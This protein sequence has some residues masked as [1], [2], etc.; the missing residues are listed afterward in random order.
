MRRVI[1]M[2]D[3]HRTFAEVVWWCSG[4]RASCARREAHIGQ[5]V[6][7]RLIHQFGELFDPRAQLI[8]DLS[9]FAPAGFGVVLGEGGAD[10][11]RPAAIRWCRLW[12]LTG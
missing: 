12:R 11:G 8:S 5:H 3:I 2:L 10:E 1:G 9:P 4:K 6:V 7:F